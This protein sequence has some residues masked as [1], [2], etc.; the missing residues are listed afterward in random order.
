MTNMKRILVIDD[1]SEIRYSLKRVLEA[2]GFQVLLAA[3]GEE[4]VE[5][6]RKER[7][8]VVLSDN[9]MTGITGLET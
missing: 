1:D 7:P 2:R 4:G 5:V 9:R 8:A 3:S 6:A